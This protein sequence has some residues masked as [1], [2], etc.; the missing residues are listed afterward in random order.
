MVYKF[1]KILAR[2]LY[3][4]IKLFLC[5][6]SMYHKHISYIMHGRANHALTILY[7][8]YAFR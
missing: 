4:I 1:S 5:I 3:F 6:H 8:V 7:I 2:Q